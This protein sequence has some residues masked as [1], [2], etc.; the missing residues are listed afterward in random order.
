MKFYVK[1]ECGENYVVEEVEEEVHDDE[2]EPE[3]E[4][5]SLTDDEILALKKLALSTDKLLALLADIKDEDADKD[6]DEGMDPKEVMDEDSEKDDEDEDE[7]KEDKKVKDS[8]SSFGSLEKQKKVVKN[9]SIDRDTAI[10]DAWSKRYG[11]A[12]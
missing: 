10:A 9:S 8:K 1:D 6:D 4:K 11:G 12:K 5:P 7:E 3:K 2:F